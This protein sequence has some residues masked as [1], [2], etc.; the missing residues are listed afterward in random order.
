MIDFKN[1]KEINTGGEHYNFDFIWTYAN[2]RE[3]VT[4]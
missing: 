3:R 4:F 2:S 1:K